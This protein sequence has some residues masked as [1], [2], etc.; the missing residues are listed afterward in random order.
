MNSP[1]TS[2]KGTN[3]RV[4]IL[5][6]NPSSFAPTDLA[7]PTLEPWTPRGHRCRQDPGCANSLNAANARGPQTVPGPPFIMIAT[8]IA[9]ATSAS[10]AFAAAEPFA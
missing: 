2:S 9:S 5:R 6:C 7:I 8:P 3:E 1:D 10:V 4:A